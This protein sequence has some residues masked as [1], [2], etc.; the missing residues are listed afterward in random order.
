MI[1]KKSIVILVLISIMA[2]FGCSPDQPTVAPPTI[3]SGDADFTRFV[4]I[5]ASFEA[6]FTDGYLEGE[7]ELNSYPAMI[8]R[9]MGLTVGTDA[10]ADFVVPYIAGGVGSKMTLAGFTETGS[11]IL[12]FEDLVNLP[13]NITHPMPFHDLGVPG[14]LAYEV[15]YTSSTA[16]SL[17]GNPLFDMILRPSGDP[18]VDKS[19][20]DQAIAL[21]PTFVLIGILGNDVLGAATSGDT[22]PLLPVD[23]AQYGQIYGGIVQTLTTALPGVD[24]VGCNLPFIS[25]LP[26]FTTVGYMVPVPDM[27]LVPLVIQGEGGAV[28]SATANDL[29]LLGASSVIGDVS[30]NYG[31]AGIPVGLHPSAPLP[32]A[33]VLDAE[34]VAD[35]DTHVEAYNT[36][37][38]EVANQ[39]DFPIAD[40]NG[41]M[42]RVSTEGVP[43]WEDFRVTSA[44]ISGGAFSLDGVH[45]TD[46]GYMIIA[47]EVI[48]TINEFY[49]SDLEYVS[50]YQ[51][52]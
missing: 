6:G 40:M 7:N 15:L 38:A 32:D 31:P 25:T 39:F 22:N 46:L 8:A 36:A 24:L 26:H 49:G 30:G 13:T 27:G 20:V 50:A 35:I 4:A 28:R 23:P 52:F 2:L 5:G 42:E 51:Y 12:E 9:Q 18:A 1:Y 34:E 16:T 33:L 29:I 37:I 10:T 19:E 11:P 14:A 21:N 48:K 3:D 47:N 45:A 43:I 44:Y 41:L 17:G